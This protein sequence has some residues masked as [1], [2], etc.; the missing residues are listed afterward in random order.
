MPGGVVGKSLNLGFAGKISRNPLMKISARMVK[1]I[2]DG[3]G[4]ETLSAIP[5]GAAVVVNADNTYSLFG[6][7]GSGVSAATYANF[8][9]IAVSEVQQSMSYGLG[10]NV[11]GNGSYLPNTPADVLQVGTTTV[12][13]KDGTPTANGLVYITTVAGG[14]IAVGD[15]VCSTSPTGGGTAV[16][17]TNARWTTGKKDASGITEITLLAQASA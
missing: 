6:D 12:F 10:T 3:N 11:S 4:A 7:S 1:S 14:S 17:V 13:C 5:F 2:L 8:G 9:G 16:Q 15:F